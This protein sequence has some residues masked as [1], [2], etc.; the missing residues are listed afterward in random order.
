MLEFNKRIV[1]STFMDPREGFARK[2]INTEIRFD[3]L[4]GES[5]R[6]AHFGA[7]KTKKVDFSSWDTSDA[8]KYC[9]FCP[10]NI[11]TATPR[12]PPEIL[13][14]GF[15]QQGEAK[16]MPNISPYDQYSSLTVMSAKHLVPL[17]DFN[18]KLLADAFGVGLK[19]FKIVSETEPGLPY[20]ILSWN[21]MPPS[22]GGLLHPHQQLIITSSPGNLYRKMYENSKLFFERSGS[23]YWKILCEVEESKKERYIGRIGRGHWIVPFV[24]LGAIGEYDVIFPEVHSIFDL[25]EADLE[26]LSEGL[27]RLF[28]YFDHKGIYS[29]NMVLY[30]A[31]I[32]Q[33]EQ[34][35]SLHARII[36]RTYLNTLW[37][38][39]D[40]NSLQ[41]LLQEPFTVE[42]PEQLCK[43]LAVYWQ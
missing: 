21:Y 6:L 7:I 32:G 4:T 35:F 17:S 18:K 20:H 27:L 40:V 14:E 13:P 11:E 9:P 33:A 36:P 2:S 30:F 39:S 41:I 43:E 16:I 37:K 8:R 19:F 22:G 29:F 5:G 15:L 28:K 23:N 31:P 42:I 25:N 12:F 1:T 38:P 26:D 34:F 3:P 24:P 10:V